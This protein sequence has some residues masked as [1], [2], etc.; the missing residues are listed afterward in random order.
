MQYVECLCL[1]SPNLAPAGQLKPKLNRGLRHPIRLL[2][3]K[4][5]E[6]RLVGTQLH[7]DVV[8]IAG[9]SVES[10][11]RQGRLTV[12][13]NAV[14]HRLNDRNTVQLHLRARPAIGNNLG[15]TLVSQV[16]RE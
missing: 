16:N 9:Y 13:N 3:S 11:L 5:R 1:V 14:E 6:G 2:W 7:G 8:V 10:G 12:L 15:V 4:E